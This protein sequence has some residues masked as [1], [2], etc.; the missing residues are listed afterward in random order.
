MY[1][2]PPPYLLQ[3]IQLMQAGR[4]ADALTYFRHA[5]RTET[6]NAEGWL[7]VASASDDFEEYQLCVEQALRLDPNHPVAQRMWDD[8]RQS[9]QKPRPRPAMQVEPSVP[10]PYA[11]APVAAVRLPRRAARLRRL[12]IVLVALLICVGGPAALVVSGV[13]QEQW[14]R[15]FGSSAEVHA[16]EFT[17]GSSYRF[18]VEVPESWMPADLDNPTWRSTRDGLAEAFPASP[19]EP[20]VWESIETSFSATV[21]NP[22][23]GDLLPKPAAI[24]ETD[25]KALKD[26][27]AIPVLELVEIG[28]LPKLSGA[29]DLCA[30]MEELK[31][32]FATPVVADYDVVDSAVLERENDCVRSIKAAPTSSGTSLTATSS[33]SSGA[34]SSAAAGVSPSP[35]ATTGPTTTNANSSHAATMLTRRMRSL[36]R[37]SSLCTSSVPG[38]V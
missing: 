13:A 2:E 33:R 19:G 12:A 22:V 27:G 30:Q 14:D 28:A 34:V 20:T 8:M 16:L 37:A 5:A 6:L 24:I 3:G 17:V 18:R 35:C 21:R 7:W 26:E 29:T 4:R 36:I 32:Q 1:N 11:T 31:R 25:R 15:W 38:I 23:Y 9:F 10:A